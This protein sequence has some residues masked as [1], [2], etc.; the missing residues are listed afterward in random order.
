MKKFKDYL[1]VFIMII[2]V[3]IAVPPVLKFNAVALGWAYE[4]A[5]IP[6]KIIVSIFVFIGGFLYGYFF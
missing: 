6:L 4:I 2:A 5:V 1:E 3:I